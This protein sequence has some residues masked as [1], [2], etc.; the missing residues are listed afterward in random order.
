LVETPRNALDSFGRRIERSSDG[1]LRRQCPLS[2]GHV[3]LLDFGQLGFHPR[4]FLLGLVEL[5]GKGKG[6]HYREAGVTNLSE[7]LAKSG[8]TLIEIRSQAKKVRL[9]AR[10]AGHAELAS[11]D[12]DIDLRHGT[13]L[14]EKAQ[15]SSSERIVAIAASSRRLTSRLTSSN[16]RARA[17]VSSSW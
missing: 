14:S 7:A 6:G 5:V 15:R 4:Q 3:G 1:C 10:F 16:D 2:R 13:S 11:I 8:D 12:R 9:L 17:D